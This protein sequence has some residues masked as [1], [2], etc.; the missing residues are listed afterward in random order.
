[1]WFLVPS[2]ALHEFA[3]DSLFSDNGDD[4]IGGLLRGV[5]VSTLTSDVEG[6]RISQFT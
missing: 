3:D 6:T 1:M 5:A 2:K 4:E